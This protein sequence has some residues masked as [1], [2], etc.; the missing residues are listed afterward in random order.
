MNA[1]AD[2]TPSPAKH[3]IESAVLVELTIDAVAAQGDGVASSGGRTIFVPYTAPGDRIRA[4]P[5]DA[6]R[7]QLVELLSAGPHRAAPPCPH[8]GPGKCGGCALQHLDDGFYNEWK[9]AALAGVLGRAGLSGFTFN[10]MARTASGQRRRAELL[11]RI[12]SRKE[13]A[14]GA[15]VT[16]GFHVRASRDAVTIGPC[17]VLTPALEN[18]LPVL[19]AFLTEHWPGP[20]AFDVLATDFGDGVELVFT[21]A[22]EPEPRLREQLVVFAE[23]ADLARIAHRPGPHAEADIVV[24][25]RSCRAMFGEVAVDLP[26]GAFMQ[27]SRAG[28]QAIVAAAR[29]ALGGARRVADLYAGAGAL[30]LS[31]AAGRRGLYAAERNKAALAALEQGAR[32]AGLGSILR[33]EA[34]DLARRPLIGEELERFDAVIFDPP[35]EGAAEQARALAAAKIATLVAVSCNPSTF[36]RDAGILIAGGYRLVSVTPVDQFLWSPHLELVAEFRR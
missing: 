26:A 14:A 23:R 9:Q 11:V 17:P 31:L 28:E 20:A 5:I 25:R 18:L 15:G 22:G 6:E 32:R 7:A 3:R 36:A 12:P 2:R 33:A 1:R 34:R 35:R 13:K 30:V 16:L 24:Q 27:A 8:F 10:P 29:A 4:Q 19:R 21:R